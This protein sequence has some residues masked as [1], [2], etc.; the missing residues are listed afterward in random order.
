M[1]V[2]GGYFLTDVFL[3]FDKKLKCR[4]FRP[5]SSLKEDRATLAGREAVKCKRLMG[6]LR[7]L[8]RNTRESSDDRVARL[9]DLLEPSPARAAGGEGDAEDDED[10]GAALED[11]QGGHDGEPDSPGGEADGVE[12]S[13]LDAL[14]EPQC[15][16]ED[17]QSE[18]AGHDGSDGEDAASLGSGAEGAPAS[19]ADG[20]EASH[21]PAKSA[22]M[23]IESDTEELLRAPTLRLGSPSSSVDEFPDSQVSSG[24][25]GKTYAH[26]H[27]EVLCWL[28]L[29]LAC[30]RSSNQL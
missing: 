7:S 18:P 28:K 1:Q 29:C 16:Q 9:K 6:A 26:Y 11:A 15:S 25:L 13:P 22:P 4:V 12:D 8:W 20:S 24:W 3:A 30:D 27:R 19:P 21:A 2:L 5:D 14:E 17:S 10:E 23:L